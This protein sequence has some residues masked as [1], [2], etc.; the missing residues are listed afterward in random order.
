M[1]IKVISLNVKGLL[2]PVKRSRVMSKLD[3]GGDST[4]GKV[5]GGSAQPNVVDASLEDVWCLE[6]VPSCKK[7]LHVLFS[8]MQ[9]LLKNGLF[10]RYTRDR[11]RV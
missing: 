7:R 2:D 1:D 8:P 6:K 3:C 4:C 10:F 11:H 5:M 9:D